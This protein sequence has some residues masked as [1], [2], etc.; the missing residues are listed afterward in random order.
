MK[1]K[2][3]TKLSVLLN[4]ILLLIL[5]TIALQTQFYKVRGF[6]DLDEHNMKE[7]FSLAEESLQSG[8]V[9]VGSLVLYEGEIIGKGY[10]T[11]FRD[12]N[13]C[14]HAE[15]NALNNAIQKCGIREFL[16]LDREK[17]EVLST[18]E[19]C[20]MCKGALNHYRIN[21]LTFTR[22]KSYSI[23]IRNHWA[24]F[25]YELTKRNSPGSIMQDSLFM[26]HPEYP[27]KK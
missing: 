18:F 17:L 13:I 16:E 23:W 7:L 12:G 8:D 11:V 21:N 2:L 3:V 5:G 15:I 1:H 4:I 14:G 9:P 27:G 20:E 26:L 22:S 25:K 10:N 19:P 6:K 24:S